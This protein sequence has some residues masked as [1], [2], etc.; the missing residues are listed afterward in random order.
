[1]ETSLR[2]LGASLPASQHVCACFHRTLF[3]VPLPQALSLTFACLST[4]MSVS[5]EALITAGSLLGLK[6]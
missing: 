6:L 2:T 3:C 4:G 5:E 1:M